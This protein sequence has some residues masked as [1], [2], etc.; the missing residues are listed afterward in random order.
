MQ[1]ELAKKIATHHGGLIQI[2]D[3]TFVF[4]VGSKAACTL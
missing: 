2:P 3:S 1:R 4:L